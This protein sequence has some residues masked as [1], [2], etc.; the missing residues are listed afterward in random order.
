MIVLVHMVA[1]K[2]FPGLAFHVKA[3]AKQAMDIAISSQDAGNQGAPNLT[4]PR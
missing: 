2:C 4:H 1:F 3:Y